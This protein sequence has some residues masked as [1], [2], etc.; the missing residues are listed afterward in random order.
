MVCGVAGHVVW[1]GWAL[2]DADWMEGEGEAPGCRHGWQIG[3]GTEG[4]QSR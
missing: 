3:K 2:Q 1:Q 4:R